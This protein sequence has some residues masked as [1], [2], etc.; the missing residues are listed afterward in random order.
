[1]NII[2][3]VNL[4]PRVIIALELFFVL[5]LCV[6]MVL[7]VHFHTQSFKDKLN[8]LNRI[9]QPTSNIAAGMQ[10]FLNNH[11]FQVLK[12]LNNNDIKQLQKIKESA[13]SFEY[14]LKRYRD[15]THDVKQKQL[16]LETNINY[17]FYSVVVSK[18]IN[19]E[20]NKSKKIDNLIQSFNDMDIFIADKLRTGFGLVNLSSQEKLD[21]IQGIRLSVNKISYNLIGFIETDNKQLLELVFQNSDILRNQIGWYLEQSILSDEKVWIKEVEQLVK[22]QDSLISNIV[23]LHIT[24][25]DHLEL[26]IEIRQLLDHII[27]TKIGN[28]AQTRLNDVKRN[29]NDKFNIINMLFSLISIFSFLLGAVM[30]VIINRYFRTSS[31]AIN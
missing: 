27:N 17:G 30:L 15:L 29:I 13:D 21:V 6:M 24:K 19:I 23:L 31:T 10:I 22:K 18:L 25:K 14:F 7:T 4:S 5:I 2:N 28:R 9:S 11:S 12:Y 20:K 16:Y 26:F 3:S 1:M 8:T